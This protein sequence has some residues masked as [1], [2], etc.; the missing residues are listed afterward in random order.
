M[1][2][3]RIMFA[4]ALLMVLGVKAEPLSADENTSISTD[5][6]VIGDINRDGK[7]DYADQE[8]VVKCIM[9]VDDDIDRS[10]VDLNS[11]GQVNATDLVIL[12]NI[13]L[14]NGVSPDAYIFIPTQ[15]DCAIVN[16]TGITSMPTKKGTNAHAWMEVWDMRGQYFKK[17]VIIDLQG[18]SST[19]HAKKNFAVDF[20][21]DEWKGDETTEIKIGNWVKQDGFHFKAY[22]TSIT[23]GECPVGYKL[24]D[25][26]IET[27]PITR[28]APYMEYYSEE[29][30][31]KKINSD[32][33]EDREEFLARCYPDGFPCIVYLNGQFYGIFSWQ[34]KKHRDNFNMGR[35][36]TDNIHIDGTLGT[37]EIWNG[38]I[39]WTS[40]EV[41]NPK[42]KKNKW[43]LM[44][45]DGT[46]YDGDNPK[47]LMGTDSEHYDASDDN[48]VNSA[49]TKAGIIELS[50][51][52]KQISEFE[53]TYKNSSADDKP[54]S[55]S[56]LKAEIEKRFSVEWMIDYLI[57]NLLIQNGDCVRKNWQWTTWGEIDGTNK[58]YPNPYDLDQAFGV[59]ATTAFQLNK[60]AKKTFGKGTKTPAKYIWDYYYDDLKARYFELR[61]AG[62]ISYD[63]VWGLMKDWVDRVGN[64]NYELESEK[65]PEMPCNRDPFIS[66]K[67]ELTGTQYITW[68]SSATNWNK[69]TRYSD[70]T[71]I[72]FNYRCYKSLQDNNV[73]HTPNEEKSEWWIDVSIKP[74][75]YKKGDLIFDGRVNYYQF[76]ALADL[77]VSEESITDR[78]DHF[79]GAP[80]EKFYSEYPFEGG[81]HDNVERIDN[82]IKEK[83]TLMDAQFG[84]QQE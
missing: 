11:D 70:G 49:K 55:L 27:K 14:N 64:N 17:R 47:E 45:Q 8:L 40:F 65:W 52:M 35:N 15:P 2:K 39:E 58:W 75:S 34:L 84:Y 4:L 18:N 29:E 23:K 83:I 5:L 57:L 21:E 25:K 46:K 82:W 38:K 66:D 43:T 50:N 30:I 26:F 28:R 48:C 74:G 3:L 13:I 76:R 44:C 33:P 71:Y 72:K 32:N 7:V 6:Y 24:Y 81:V 63:V 20:C 9:N 16:I 69:N 31:I 37:D 78:P 62:V 42:P 61:N 19:A 22:Y 36:K 53:T 10:L 60:P 51:Y 12:T 67:W 56:T 79:V 80:F 59:V 77:V 68:G 54:A 41:R 73:G 1:R